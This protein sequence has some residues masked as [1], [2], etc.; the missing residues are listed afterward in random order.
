MNNALNI[1]RNKDGILFEVK[2][3]PRSSKNEI[4]GTVDGRLK[5]KL[6]QPPV[7]G[8]AN[9]ALI[10]LISEKLGIRKN[11]IELARGETST[12]KQIRIRQSDTVIEDKLN[13][14]CGL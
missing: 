4:T 13:K 6:M 11:Q 10:E 8:K 3:I 9:S 14:L 2:V 12:L 5:V 1:A 7:D